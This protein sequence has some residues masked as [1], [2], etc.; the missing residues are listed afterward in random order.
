[1][2]SITLLFAALLI[3]VV[4][5]FASLCVRRNEQL[6]INLAGVGGILGGVLGILACIPALIGSEPILATF[7]TPFDFAQFSV[8]MDG[9]AAF[10]VL[11]ISL[12][13]IITSL[14]SFAY[15]AEYKGKGAGT[16]GFFMNILSHQWSL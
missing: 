13:T 8:R 4:A 5:A 9:L 2:S 11:V 1:M 7:T 6:S 14:Y 15:V 10:M 16:M 12:L 3:Y